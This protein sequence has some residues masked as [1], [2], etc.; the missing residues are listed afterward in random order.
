M[1]LD[2]YVPIYMNGENFSPKDNRKVIKYALTDEYG[3]SAD[4]DEFFQLD[5]N[6]RVI[7]VDDYDAIKKNVGNHFGMNIKIR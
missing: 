4:I 5:V 7:I 2:D 6:K 3:D 1:L